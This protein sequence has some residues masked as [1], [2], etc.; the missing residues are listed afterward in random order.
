MNINIQRKWLAVGLSLAA[1]IGMVAGASTSGENNQ[2]S[3]F[4][5]KM[6]HWQEE[7]SRTF[8]EAQKK[9]EA[10]PSKA[11]G[12]GA[13][14]SVDLREQSD[15]YVVRLNL[16]GRTLANVAVALDGD[17]LL[18]DAP[19]EGRAG[20]Y[21]QVLTLAD[22]TGA[23]PEIERQPENHL[24]VVKVPKSTP[25]PEASAAPLERRVPFLPLL[26]HERD[27]LGRMDRMQR[28]MDRIFADEF[29]EFSLM[30]SHR[31]FF[32]RSRFGSS[33]DMKDQGDSYLVNAWLPGRDTNNVSVTTDG[34][35]LRI[36]AKS[37]GKEE[38]NA[39]GLVSRRS[40][41]SQVLTLPGPVSPD[42]M[43][44]ER[45]EG[46]L[47]ITLPKAPTPSK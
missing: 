19:A 14:A 21:Q 25:R 15:S 13:T 30:P 35:T 44:V 2:P 16:P 17:K 45:K 23:K 26:D 7:M 6:K 11:P 28:E 42:Q 18:I 5:E 22:A 31:D 40:R 39:E 36:E 9:Q 27:F 34:T 24:M 46:M 37:E 3:G 8:R 10:D 4:F 33:V 38:K 12:A 32:D 41:Y 20:K 47:V 29:K 1:G 43:K